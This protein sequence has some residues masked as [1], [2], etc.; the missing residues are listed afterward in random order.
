MTLAH[1]MSF[2]CFKTDIIGLP[3]PH[4]SYI[5]LPTFC[6]SF[7]LTYAHLNAWSFLINTGNLND[8]IMVGG[9]NYLRPQIR[10]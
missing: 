4:P 3:V 9:Y 7:P 8:I 5:S 2:P 10:Y 6:T 1:I